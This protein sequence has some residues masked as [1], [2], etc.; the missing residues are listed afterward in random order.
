MV[1]GPG[2]IVQ[3]MFIR[4]GLLIITAIT[5]V[6]EFMALIVVVI[7][8]FIAAVT[9]AVLEFTVEVGNIKSQSHY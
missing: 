4:V 1:T 3:V 8:V 6:A 2:I 9:I 5:M 7:E